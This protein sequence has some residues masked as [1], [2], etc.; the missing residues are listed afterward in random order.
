VQGHFYFFESREID[1]KVLY[2]AFKRAGLIFEIGEIIDLELLN[3]IIKD[4]RILVW[5]DDHISDE[6]VKILSNAREINQYGHTDLRFRVFNINET[7]HFGKIIY[8]EKFHAK[9]D[10][11]LKYVVSY[12]TVLPNRLMKA[13]INLAYVKEGD[14]ILD[15]FVGT[16]R[17]L[18]IASLMGI[19]GLGI[20]VDLKMIALAEK[21]IDINNLSDH[22]KIKQGNAMNLENINEPVNGIVTD[23]PYGKSSSLKGVSIKELYTKSLEAME[24][25][26]DNNRYCIMIFPDKAL[27]ELASPFFSIRN[28]YPSRV[29]KSLTRYITRMYKL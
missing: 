7:K 26:L 4:N 11:K 12:P 29:H 17:I 10:K 14:N 16:A 19:N 27:I 13:M 25:I 15:P 9:M 23:P 21:N 3:I 6:T 1:N 22:V 18:M 24:R 8:S 28:I 2:I 20:D 5:E